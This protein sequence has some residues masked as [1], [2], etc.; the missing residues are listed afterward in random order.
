VC[1]YSIVQDLAIP[2]EYNYAITSAVVE[3][4]DVNVSFTCPEARDAQEIGGFY[5]LFVAPALEVDPL[6]PPK[7]AFE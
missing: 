5:S 4:M 1:D 2:C 7:V 3:G 6:F